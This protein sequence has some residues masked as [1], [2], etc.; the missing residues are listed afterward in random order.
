[1]VSTAARAAHVRAKRSW[2]CSNVSRTLARRAWR[3]RAGVWR[4]VWACECSWG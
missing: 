4:G 2:G 1:M 3:K